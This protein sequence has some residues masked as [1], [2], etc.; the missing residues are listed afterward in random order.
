MYQKKRD[1]RSI[2]SS[3]WIYT[4][5]K[6]L[7]S[8]K[9]FSKIT[10][11]D[12]V[13]KANLGRT[14]FYRNFDSIDDVLK[15][16]CDE[17][18][19]EFRQYC[20][21]YYKENDV[22]DKSFLTPFLKYWYENS[23]IIELLIKANRETII[24]DCLT[25]EVKFFINSSSINKDTIISA[26]INYFI[27]MIVSNSISIL[28]EWINNDKNIPPDELANIIATQAKESVKVNLFL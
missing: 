2:Q 25:E 7:M 21:S 20:I 1:K 19:N 18:F 3:E 17:K 6:D 8:E 22:A 5:L 24:K 27:A 28:T 10:I 11:T 26:H 12:I 23:E 14:T 15:M 16:K 9:D 13:N 4:A